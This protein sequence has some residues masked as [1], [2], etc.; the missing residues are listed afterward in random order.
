MA[1]IISDVPFSWP[2]SWPSDVP[3]SWPEKDDRGLLDHDAAI[4]AGK[5][6]LAEWLRRA[7]KVWV[8]HRKKQV[9]LIKRLNWLNNLTRQDVASSFKVLHNASGTNLCACVVDN[10]DREQW[11]PHSIGVQGFVADSKTY[12]VE[13]VNENE[14]HYLCAMLNAPIVDKMIKPFQTKGQFGA[15]SGKGERDIHRRPFQ[16]VP[17]PEFSGDD[18]RHKKLA[19]LSADCHEK[20]RAVVNDAVTDRKFFT[21]PIARIRPMLRQKMLAQELAAIDELASEIIER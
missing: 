2:F 19:K 13:C 10:R 5:S 8:A 3:F 20:I 4:R 16:H 1:R 15:K 11:H 21:G 9:S 7:D 6:G 12:Y 17:I 18:K 14:A